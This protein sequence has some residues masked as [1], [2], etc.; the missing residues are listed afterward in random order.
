MQQS[1]ISPAESGYD[2]AD[3]SQNISTNENSKLNQQIT[4]QPHKTDINYRKT[5]RR[6]KHDFNY[7]QNG[8]KELIK[9]SETSKHDSN[10][11][12]RPDNN[13]EASVEGVRESVKP[14]T[15]IG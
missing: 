3:F 15:L 1:N 5:I 9:S 2:S 11:T 6:V 13:Q 8:D 10:T 4:Y 12:P 7:P 14:A